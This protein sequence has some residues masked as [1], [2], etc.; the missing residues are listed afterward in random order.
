[1]AAGA[2]A[3]GACCTSRRLTQAQ[4]G[5]VTGGGVPISTCVPPTTLL[6]PLA[7]S[8]A[9]LLLLLH[10]PSPAHATSLV[11]ADADGTIVRSVSDQRVASQRNASAP[12]PNPAVVPLIVAVAGEEERPNKTAVAVA[13]ARAAG[14]PTAAVAMEAGKRGEAGGMSCPRRACSVWHVNVLFGGDTTKARALRVGVDAAAV[15]AAALAKAAASATND[16][17][18]ATVRY[19]HGLY[20]DDLPDDFDFYEDAPGGGRRLGAGPIVAIVAAGAI[21]IVS[22]AGMAGTLLRGCAR[23]RKAKGGQGG[24]EGGVEAGGGEGR[25]D[26]AARAKPVLPVAPHAA[27]A[28]AAATTN[29]HASLADHETADVARAAMPVAPE[30]VDQFERTLTV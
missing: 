16:T 19:T 29:G 25:P 9:L 6:S 4:A 30:V 26:A 13:L 27:A 23:R 11:Q 28:A 21:L 17:V 14:V 15:P 3:A 7:T 24:G 1:M 12:P 18:T 20:A 10:P 22:C 8:T 2:A 5:V